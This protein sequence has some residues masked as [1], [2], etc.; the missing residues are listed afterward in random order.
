MLDLGDG[1][2]FSEKCNGTYLTPSRALNNAVNGTQWL[3]I[4]R[5]E[6][7]DATI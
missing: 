7:A 6:F 2:V 3:F 1:E 4:F 5:K